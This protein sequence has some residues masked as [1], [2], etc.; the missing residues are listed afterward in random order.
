MKQNDEQMQEASAEFER[1][2]EVADIL[3]RPETMEAEPIEDVPRP[4]SRLSRFFR[5]VLLWSVGLIG[6]FA[7]G[8]G[9]TWVTQVSRL[10]D[11]RRALLDRVDALQAESTAALEALRAE[12]SAEIEAIQKD[13]DDAN[14]HIQLVNALVDVSSARVALGQEDIVGVRAALAGTDERLATLQKELG[15]DGTSAVQALRDQLSSVLGALGEDPTLTDQELERLIANLL[16][17]ER[18]VFSE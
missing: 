11:E 13:I 2:M 18:S 1:D 17:L 4:P 3:D 12:H 10:Q 15:P 14:L 7:L 9:A 8:V 6:V 5:R 16:A